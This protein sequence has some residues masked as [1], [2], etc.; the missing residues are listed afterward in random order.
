MSG[1][2]KYAMINVCQSLCINMWIKEGHYL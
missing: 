2:N 1:N